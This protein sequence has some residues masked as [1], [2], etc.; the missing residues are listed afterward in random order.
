LLFNQ[1]AL[2]PV[3]NLLA[4]FSD[5]FKHANCHAWVDDDASSDMVFCYDSGIMWGGPLVLQRVT[6]TMIGGLVMGA[7]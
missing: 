2:S 3:A 7:T 1:L 6:E 5:Q 4:I